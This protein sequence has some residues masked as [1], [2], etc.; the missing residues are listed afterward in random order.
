MNIAPGTRWMR[1]FWTL[2]HLFAWRTDRLSGGDI[3][4]LYFMETVLANI[5][6][7]EDGEEMN[8]HDRE[9]ACLYTFR[10]RSILQLCFFFFTL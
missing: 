6:C 8:R 5:W 7:A 1:G 4:K 9:V 2:G 10:C 3:G